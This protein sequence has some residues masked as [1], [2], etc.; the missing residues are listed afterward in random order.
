MSS[1]QQTNFYNKNYTNT[2][3][4]KLAS[5]QFDRYKNSSDYIDQSQIETILKKI[6]C[7]DSELYD[8]TIANRKDDNLLEFFELMDMDGD[9]KVSLE[10]L[11][12]FT[13]MFYGPDTGNMGLIQSSIVS[14]SSQKL[15]ENTKDKLL[16]SQVPYSL[17]NSVVSLGNSSIYGALKNLSR[18]NTLRKSMSMQ[19]FDQNNLDIALDV[20]DT[21]FDQENTG[22]IH[23][24]E[25]PAQVS[26]ICF[27]LDYDNIF[28]R[29]TINDALTKN[30]LLKNGGKINRNQFADLYQK[31][32]H[33][34]SE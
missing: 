22:I 26:R 19:Q 30:D 10:D 9:G 17:K 18:K 14:D 27:I 34:I 31:N 15:P 3:S 28:D 24:K 5:Y 4:E 1:S 8:N 16:N 23:T 29:Q 25:I 20:F 13:N 2:E 7:F 33:Q 21:E 11:K 32:F 6:Y 12:V